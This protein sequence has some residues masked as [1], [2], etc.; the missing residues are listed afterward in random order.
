MCTISLNKMNVV[1]EL[2][3]P[4]VYNIIVPLTATKLHKWKSNCLK[5]GTTKLCYH[6][7]VIKHS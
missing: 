4:N 1:Y 7:Y 3:N 6:G 2:N 5:N